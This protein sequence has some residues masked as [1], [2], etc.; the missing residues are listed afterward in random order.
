M[1]DFCLDGVHGNLLLIIVLR[2]FIFFFHS[3]L[4]L[5]TSQ[6]L[7]VGRRFGCNDQLLK[8]AELA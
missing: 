2:F 6:L 1:I 8:V 3:S 4:L 5:L 7:S